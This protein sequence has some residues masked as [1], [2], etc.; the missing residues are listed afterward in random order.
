M[1]NGTMPPKG[2]CP[3]SD[4]L[5]PS[6]KQPQSKR[7]TPNKAVTEEVEAQRRQAATTPIRNSNKALQPHGTSPM[8]TTESKEDKGFEMSSNLM[9]LPTDADS[10]IKSDP[11]ESD[12]ESKEDSLANMIASVRKESFK[13]TPLAGDNDDVITLVATAKSKKWVPI[14]KAKD[15]TMTLPATTNNLKRRGATFAADTNFKE[16]EGQPTKMTPAKAQDGI[17]EMKE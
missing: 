15:R 13:V 5:I 14:N 4:S 1:P 8:K 17:E 7:K 6:L 16:R 12:T 9:K 11:K 2:N 10:T 3:T